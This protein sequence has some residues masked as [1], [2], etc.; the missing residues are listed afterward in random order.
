VVDVVDP[1]GG[2]VGQ[3]FLSCDR[4]QELLLPPSLREWLP[5]DHLAWFVLDGVEAIDLSVFYGDYRQD[6]HGRAA[7]DPGM[8]VALLLY[9]Y[10]I[11]ERT[12]RRIERRCYEDIAFRVICANRAPDHATIARCRVR[13]ER[14]LAD[15]FTQVLV[16]CHRAGVVSVGLVAIDGSLISGDASPQATKTYASI[17]KEVEAILDEAAQA[18][19]ADD[20]RFGDARGDD[21]RPSWP[22]RGHAASGCGAA[23][24]S[25]RPSRPSSSRPT[26]RICVGAPNGRPST[27]ASS[28]VASR[29]RPIPRRDDSAMSKIGRN[30]LC[31]CGSGRKVKRCC[32]VARG[33][34]EQSLALAFL[35]TA[36]REVAGPAG[37]LTETEFAARLG[38]L[39]DLPCLDLSLQVE[40]PKL[41]SPALG[42]CVRRSPR[43]TS[44]PVRRYSMGC[45]TSSTRQW[46]VRGLLGR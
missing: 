1:G 26:S 30:V 44:L 42:G 27:A 4:E 22:T 6:G 31:S 46:S 40:L 2:L 5:Q 37:R 17:R 25:S 24:R 18:D 39:V 43:M 19:A 21:C 9:S 20:A 35:R 7:H 28:A 15:I 41:L 8:M 23:G 14:V 3:N 33:P 38:E 12:S 36:A 29:R 16:L 13:H 32:G 11:G 34:S 10:A 45:S